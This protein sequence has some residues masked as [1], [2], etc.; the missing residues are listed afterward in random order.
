[1]VGVFAGGSSLGSFAA[2]AE[3]GIVCSFDE[4]ADGTADTAAV[5]T[6]SST[7]S[8]SSSNTSKEAAGL[9]LHG[10]QLTAADLVSGTPHCS[11]ITKLSL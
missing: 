5:A 9:V 8:S 4:H 7:S 1:M 2:G 10:E 3:P 11:V 6:D